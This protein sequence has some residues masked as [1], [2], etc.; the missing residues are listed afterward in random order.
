[1]SKDIEIKKGFAAFEDAVKTEIKKENKTISLY[2]KED[3]LEMLDNIVWLKSYIIDM[4]ESYSRT[5][6]VVEAL[7]LLA[8]EVGYEKLTAEYGDKLANAKPRAGRRR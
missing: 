2:L 3:E 5:N 1:M 6:I 7:Q 4:G 8:N